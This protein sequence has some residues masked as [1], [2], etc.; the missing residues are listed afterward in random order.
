VKVFEAY[1]GTPLTSLSVV[2][3]N[4]PR[5]ALAA[6]LFTGATPAANAVWGAQGVTKRLRPKEGFEQLSAR[7]QVKRGRCDLAVSQQL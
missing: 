3:L 5:S 6:I 4:T 2:L 1:L 7:V